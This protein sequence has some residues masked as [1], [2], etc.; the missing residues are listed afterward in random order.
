MSDEK[1]IEFTRIAVL[2]DGDNTTWAEDA[3]II[4][5]PLSEY[6]SIVESDGKACRD[7]SGTS[8]KGALYCVESIS[9]IITNSRKTSSADCILSP[10]D[11]LLIE[12]LLEEFGFIPKQS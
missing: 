1:E 9:E 2:N 4:D 7:Y 6:D 3:L 8:A 11:H 5:V 10:S 12:E